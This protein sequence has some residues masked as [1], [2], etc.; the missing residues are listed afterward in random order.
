MSR[1]DKNWLGLTVLLL[2]ILAAFFLVNPLFR[3][4]CSRVFM[5]DFLG[6]AHDTVPPIMVFTDHGIARLMPLLLMFLLWGAVALWVYHDAERRKHSGL[7]WGLFVFIGNIIG[8]IIYLIV[9]TSSA[10]TSP[11][12]A[13]AVTAKCPSCAQP[14]QNTYV[15]CPHC[16]INL[17]KKC[18][19]CGKNMELNWKVCPYC[20]QAV[21]DQET[22]S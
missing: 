6:I 22:T 3:F 2:V 1:Q 18:A 7:L 20:G 8:F 11:T 10:D 5:H 14:I 19:D 13:T 17:V 12:L 4:S 15:A 16:G 21:N 9:R